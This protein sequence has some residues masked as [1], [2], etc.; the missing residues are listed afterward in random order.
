MSPEAENLVQEV[1]KLSREDRAFQAE[2]LL[3]SPDFEEPFELSEAWKEEIA[4]RRREAETGAVE[5]I[6]AETVRK[7]AAERLRQ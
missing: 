4:R 6:P 1:L 2:R 3:E 7:D 5:L